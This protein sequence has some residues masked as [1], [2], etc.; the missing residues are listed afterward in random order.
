ML[1][2]PRARKIIVEKQLSPEQ[3]TADANFLKSYGMTANE[4]MKSLKDSALYKAV[5]HAQGQDSA[6]DKVLDALKGQMTPAY[7]ERYLKVMLQKP[8]AREAIKNS[9]LTPT[10]AT[11]IY[12]YG[13]QGYTEVQ[14]ALRGQSDEAKK[15]VTPLADACKRGFAKLPPVSSDINMT[16]RGTGV[17]KHDKGATYEDPAFV[18]TSTKEDIARNFT[19]GRRDS[20]PSESDDRRSEK[21]M[22]PRCGRP[23]RQ[24]QGS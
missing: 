6:S 12:L 13:Y 1:Q 15:L 23:L 11:A 24:R 4:A 18:S 17:F 5:K 14:A 19:K 10:E 21:G 22:L 16:Y 2:D 7:L 8:S 9:G 3:A 20:I